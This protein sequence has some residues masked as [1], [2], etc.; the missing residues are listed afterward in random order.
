[1]AQVQTFEQGFLHDGIGARTCDDLQS[2]KGGFVGQLATELFQAFSQRGGIGGH[3]LGNAFQPNGAV[4]NRIH[5][6]HHRGQHLG[7]ANVGGGFFAANVLLARLQSQAVGW[8]AVDIHTHAHQ[9]AWHGAFV[10]ISA[11]QISCMRATRA[12]GHAQAL[13]GAHHNVGAHFAGRCEQG[14][15]QQVSCHNECGLS[16]MRCCNGVFQIVRHARGGWVLRHHSKVIVL[17]HEFGGIAHQHLQ[18]QR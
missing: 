6:S 4:I 18:A 14:Q 15:G 12:H 9:T 11:S 13:G 10:V 2:V 16:G 8:I 1:M 7:C 17:S 5:A 3:A